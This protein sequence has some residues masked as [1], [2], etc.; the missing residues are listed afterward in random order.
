M[1]KTGW[2]LVWL[3]LVGTL[4]RLSVATLL[5]MP[6]TTWPL[7]ATE[8]ETGVFISAFIESTLGSGVCT[9]KKYGIPEAGSVQKLGDTCSDELRLILRL[10]ATVL[11]LRPSCAARERSISAVKAGASTSC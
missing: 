10:V 5:S 9:A 4:S 8:L 3:E 2:M 11:A 7:N 6:G 1:S